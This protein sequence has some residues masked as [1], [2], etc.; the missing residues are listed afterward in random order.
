MDGILLTMDYMTQ[1]M[2]V[3][4]LRSLGVPRET[5]GKTPRVLMLRQAA[6]PLRSVDPPMLWSLRTP[7]LR[8][9]DTDQHMV[10]PV[11]RKLLSGRPVVG[12]L[13]TT[14]GRHTPDIRFRYINTKLFFTAEM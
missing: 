2:Y 12:R 8:P 10:D 6:S 7:D 4:L 1:P 13:Y 3:C 11:S 14:S 9:R 5:T